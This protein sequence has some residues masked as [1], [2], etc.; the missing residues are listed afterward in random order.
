MSVR[1]RLGRREQFFC[2]FDHAASLLDNW[3]NRDSEMPSLFIQGHAA[4]KWRSE[5]TCVVQSLGLKRLVPVTILVPECSLLGAGSWY[6]A[7]GGNAMILG[8]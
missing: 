3:V 6:I 4:G 7:N 1:V 5:G 2:F 8:V